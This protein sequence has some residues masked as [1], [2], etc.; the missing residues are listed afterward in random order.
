[1]LG[2]KKWIVVAVALAITFPAFAR[3]PTNKQFTISAVSSG[4]LVQM[5]R[6]REPDQL[7]LDPCN[8]Y[9][10]ATADALALGELICPKYSDTYTL[11]IVG[12]VRKAILENPQNW[13]QPPV[14]LIYK[15]LVAHFPCKG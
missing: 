14:S 4:A 9:I 6:A 12:L 5:C 7:L 2:F 11:M 1:M 3:S 8:T 10:V 13:D 15:A